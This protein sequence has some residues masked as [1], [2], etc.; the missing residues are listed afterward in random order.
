MK[1][2]NCPLNLPLSRRRFSLYVRG[3]NKTGGVDRPGD[4]DTIGEQDKILGSGLAD[5]I[6]EVGKSG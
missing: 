3:Q 5:S 2:F 6:S 1:T 4:Q